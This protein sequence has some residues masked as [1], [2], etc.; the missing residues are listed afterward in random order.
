MTTGKRITL[1]KKR[2]A[3]AK[4]DYAWQTDPE[5]VKLDAAFTLNMTYQQYV[6]EY[7]FEL[8]YPNSKRHE[9]GID[10][11]EGEHIGNC[12]YYNVNQ[13]EG[14]TELGIMIGNRKCWNKGYGA[15]AVNALL[16]HIFLKTSLESV[17]LTTL[18]WN[19][20][21]QKCFLKC[22]FSKCGQVT[23]DGYNFWLMAIDR[24]EWE[25]KRTRAAGPDAAY[26]SAE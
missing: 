14:K 18:D 10:T 13:I 17:Y 12:V 1:R 23:R 7:T 16:E 24:K 19:L 6:S 25:K 26:A 22:G 3:D 8:S 9:F 5:L 20:R 4:D 2:L 21:A 15:E 11:L